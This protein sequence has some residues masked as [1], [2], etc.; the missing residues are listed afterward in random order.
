MS[1]DPRRTIE[2]LQHK[3]TQ[4][5]EMIYALANALRFFEPDNPLLARLRKTHDNLMETKDDE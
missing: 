2:I 4:Q 5:R 1:D 3:L